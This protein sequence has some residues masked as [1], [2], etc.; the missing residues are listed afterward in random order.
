MFAFTLIL[1]NETFLSYE[2]IQETFTHGIQKLRQIHS[3]WLSRFEFLEVKAEH[4]AG[5]ILTLGI[6]LKLT[7]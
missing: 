1:C 6:P 3:K 7:L 2:Q 5:G 4:T